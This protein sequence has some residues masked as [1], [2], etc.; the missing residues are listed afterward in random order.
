MR[1][2][3]N[4]LTDTCM[5]CAPSLFHDLGNKGKLIRIYALSLGAV[6]SSTQQLYLYIHSALRWRSI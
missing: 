3:V 6:T 4:T 2:K 1:H 5:Y